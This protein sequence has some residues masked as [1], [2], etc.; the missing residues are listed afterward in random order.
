MAFFAQVV[1]HSVTAVVGTSTQ[2]VQDYQ[3]EFQVLEDAH[4]LPL[5]KLVKIL[6][7]A[8]ARGCVF[9]YS[10]QGRLP[11]ELERLTD[12]VLV[13]TQVGSGSNCH[14]AKKTSLIPPL[15]ISLLCLHAYENVSHMP[16]L[17]LAEKAAL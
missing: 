1:S 16:H 2:I 14:L 11:L 10:Y 15:P 5:D 12:N 3:R 4:T 17:Y 8:R 13:T 6:T 7:A 9:V